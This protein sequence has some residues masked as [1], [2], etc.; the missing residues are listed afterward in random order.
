MSI[1]YKVTSQIESGVMVITVNNPP[2]NA[3][4]IEVRKGLREAIAELGRNQQAQCAVI[5]GS[6]NTFIAGSDIKEF[7]LPLAEPHLPEV[8]AAIENC[9]KPV[10]CAIHGAALGGGF[11]LALACD[12]RIAQDG[13]VVGLPEVTLGIIPGAGGTQRLPR[14]IG[15]E[16]SI[17]YI[18]SGARIK[19]PEALKLGLVSKVVR[20]HLLEEAITLAKSLVGSKSRI[21]DLVTP[22][23]NDADV[24]VASQKALKAGKNRPNIQKAIEMICNS[25]SMPIDQALA[26]ERAT[27]QDLRVST[28]A[29][30]LRHQFFAERKLFRTFDA[31]DVKPIELKH[32]AVIG[33]GTM[34]T[35]IAIAC[36][37]AGYEVLLL[38]QNEAA[39]TNGSNKVR[40]FYESRLQNG[41]MSADRV[42]QILTQFTYSADWKKIHNADLVIEAVFEDIEVKHAVFR[43]I[44]EHARQDAL[45][46]SN[47][48]YLDIDAIASRLENPSR[49]FGLHFFSPAQVMKLIEIVRCLRSSA[50]AIATGLQLAKRLGK[51]PVISANAFGFIGNRIYAAYRRQCEFMLEEGAYPAQI[52]KALEDY[53][54]AMGPFA[55]GDMS[56]LDIAWGMRKSQ[57][58]TRNPAHRYVTIPDSLCIAGRLGRKTGAGYYRYDANSGERSEDPGVHHIIEEA[59][60]AKGI[61]RRQFSAAEIIDRV[62]LAMINEIAHL[63]CE[64]VVRDATD[65]DVALV[66]GY[67]FPKWQGGPVF[68]ARTLGLEKLNAQMDLLEKQSGPGFHRAELHALFE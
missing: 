29:K 19:A 21:R 38:D 47:T 11:E 7:A 18:C 60:K 54:F 44:E 48:S 28:E 61:V 8:I 4:S 57:A 66:N 32:I 55:V 49:V 31:D 43:K 15:V 67:G 5:I 10:V 13:A 46:A 33:A 45:L 1:N 40:S 20:E 64:H 39:L 24:V 34:G 3:G 35:G 56:G 65:C 50:V 12:A 27:F 6:G 37:T 51:T 14:L 41:K 59:S 25:V 53:G 30:A 52:D 22:K 23:A 63:V 68:V 17:D 58:A 2:I 9:P 36:L 42:S 62:L 26:L 16:K